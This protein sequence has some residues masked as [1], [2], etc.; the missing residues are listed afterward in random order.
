M[1]DTTIL[2]E[3]D[4]ITPIS[5]GGDMWDRF[6]LRTLCNKC[7]KSKTRKDFYDIKIRRKSENEEESKS[8]ISLKKWLYNDN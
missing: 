5:L 4:H 1:Y 2:L 7:H 6:N 8:Y 3:V